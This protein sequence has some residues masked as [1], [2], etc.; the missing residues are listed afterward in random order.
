MNTK[1]YAEL[2]DEVSIKITPNEGALLSAILGTYIYQNN[3]EA[4][5]TVT[6]LLAKISPKVGC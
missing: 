4:N 5:T 6:E 2:L 3:L 1:T